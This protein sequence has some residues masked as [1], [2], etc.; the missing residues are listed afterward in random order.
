MSFPANAQQAVNYR[1]APD[2]TTITES[3]KRAVCESF[4]KLEETKRRGSEAEQ[5][6]ASAKASVSCMGL[7]E[8]DITAAK[9]K[10]PLTPDMKTTFKARIEKCDRV[11]AL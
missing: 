7:V 5:T 6:S 9:A 11:S 2:C 8:K 10:G 4:K 1:P 3:G